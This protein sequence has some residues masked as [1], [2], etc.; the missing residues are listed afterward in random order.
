VI[1]ASSAAWALGSAVT[2]AFAD[3]GIANAT[4]V[5]PDYK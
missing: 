3:A 4:L 2:R 5:E 1:A